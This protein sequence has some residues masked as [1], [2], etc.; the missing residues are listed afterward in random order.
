MSVRQGN[1]V[2]DG[3]DRTVN[4]ALF[5]ND[6]P[7]VVLTIQGPMFELNV[8]MRPDELPLLDGVSEADWDSRGSLRIGRCGAAPVFWSSDAEHLSILIGHDNETWDFGVTLPRNT[9]KD[10]LQEIRAEQAVAADRA[11]PR[12]G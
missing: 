6:E 8:W 9:L 7:A 11:K 12:S 1:H 4:D 3:I 5:E 2:S 10:I